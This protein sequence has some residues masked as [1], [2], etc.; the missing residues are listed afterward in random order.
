[1]QKCSYQLNTNW[2]LKC[3]RFN[4]PILQYKR[5]LNCFV[6]I[7]L[8]AFTVPAPV[9]FLFYLRF[10]AELGAMLS[11]DFVTSIIEIEVVSFCADGIHLWY[12]GHMILLI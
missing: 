11:K 8:Y 7:L 1:M 3:P 6:I 12:Q 4:I 9:E 10:S 2:V 5:T